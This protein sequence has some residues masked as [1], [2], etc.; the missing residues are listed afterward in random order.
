[1]PGEERR[2]QL[3]RKHGAFY[4]LSGRFEGGGMLPPGFEQRN[5]LLQQYL[6]LASGPRFVPVLT[7]KRWAIV[8]RYKDIKGVKPQ[9]YL[10]PALKLL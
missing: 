9:R 8:F 5:A 4:S 7:N 2:Y 3:N 6:V 10:K 1:M